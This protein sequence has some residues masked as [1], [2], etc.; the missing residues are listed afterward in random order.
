M[1]EKYIQPAIYRYC[2]AHKYKYVFP[3]V[4]AM[5]G[6]SDVLSV[7][8]SG[9][10]TEFE[11]KTNKGDYIADKKK[12][13]K[14]EALNN[15][16][17]FPFRRSL[18]GEIEY[19][20]MMIPNYF[21]YVSPPDIITEV[22]HFA[23]LMHYQER[24][25]DPNTGWVD[26]IKKAPRL[27]R[28]KFSDARLLRI[29]G[30][31]SHR[32]WHMQRENQEMKAR[33]KGIHFSSTHFGVNDRVKYIGE[34]NSLRGEFATMLHSNETSCRVTFD[35]KEDGNIFVMSPHEFVLLDPKIKYALE[36]ILAADIKEL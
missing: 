36:S 18:F 35:N 16:N 30:N 24:D 11:I 31:I 1:T 5:L 25:K 32:F 28:E 2:K 12:K 7:L 34:I 33:I 22:P 9:H 8:P 3:N 26:L 14:H 17:P 19:K 27:H 4:H 23:G 21:Y 15:K 29:V 20:H 10:V 6:E 13:A